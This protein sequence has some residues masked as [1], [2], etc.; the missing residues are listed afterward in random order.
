[1]NFLDKWAIK[2]VESKIKTY[3]S[4]GSMSAYDRAFFE[5][6]FKTTGK[7][8][9]YVGAVYNAIEVH[10]LYYSKAKFRV[11][12]ETEKGIVEV[13][14]HPFMS[15]FINPHSKETW[16]RYA[17]LMAANW[18][19]WGVNYFYVNRNKLT[20]KPFGYQQ[21][22]PA[23]I[24]KV[25]NEQGR[26]INYKY[27]DGLNEQDIPIKDMIEIQYPNPYSS[28]K[29]MPI[30]DTVAD[31]T[32]VNALQMHYMRKF[33]ENGGFMGLVFTTNQA[34]TPG[35]FK[36]T[37]EM[38]ESKFQGKDAAYKEVGLFDS[39][40]SPVKAAYS[41][42]DMDITNSRKATKEDIYEA[43][44]V[45]DILVGRGNMDR[46]GNEAA[47]FQFTSGIIDPLMSYVDS[48]FSLFLRTEWKDDTLK[49]EH[50]TLAP[51]DQD[52]A[53]KYYESGL[54]NGWLSINEVRESENYNELEYELAEIPTVNVGGALIN[55]ETGKQIGVENAPANSTNVP[56]K[57]N[58]PTPDS[59]DD[60]DE[61]DK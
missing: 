25:Y 22:P 45:S 43:W 33:F 4:A 16:W 14:D 41:I 5:N 29:G 61:D 44:K 40:L 21:I 57:E 39:G 54:K 60:G 1:M 30:I 17:Y 49:V 13:K 35:N 6:F 42:N 50:D 18:G 3:S 48:C 46:A 19:L 37:L 59:T 8:E 34:M 9:D 12:Q 27:T 38:L 58:K 10:G 7:S 31:Q 28:N 52:A 36:R 51:K 23:L 56:K 15:M 20:K 11:Y 24:E 47:I 32:T 53:L 26:L 55:L 2:R